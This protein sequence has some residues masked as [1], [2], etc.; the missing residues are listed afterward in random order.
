MGWAGYSVFAKVRALKKFQQAQEIHFLLGDGNNGGDGYVIAWQILSSSK[1]KIFLWQASPPKTKDSLYFFNLCISIKGQIR[2]Y[3]LERFK[4][5][6]NKKIVVFDALFGTGFKGTLDQKTQETFKSINAKKKAFKIAIDI[7]SGVYADGNIFTHLPF[8]ADI[9][10][11]FGGYKIGHLLHPGILFSG[12]VRVLP[13]GFPPKKFLQRRFLQKYK[14]K[15]LRTLDSHKY[16]NGVIHIYGGSKGMEGAAI[17]SAYSFLKLGGG[18]VKIYSDSEDIKKILSKKPEMMFPALGVKEKVEKA[19]LGDLK[20]PV[21]TKMSEKKPKVLVIG[22]GLKEKPSLSFWEELLQIRHLNIILD[23]SVLRS[24]YE[25][26]NIFSGH[27]NGSLTLTPHFS[28]AESL[29]QEEITNVRE[30]TLRISKAYN[31][32][33]YFKGAGGL[34][35][36]PPKYGSRSRPNEIFVFSKDSQ[37]AVGGTG[38]IL[39][40]VIANMMYRY[41]EPLKAIETALLLYLKISRKTAGYLD[42][43]DKAYLTSSQL[44]SGF[45]SMK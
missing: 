39:T 25:Y 32:F 4:L 19:L 31:A 17:L 21:G 26:K 34:I 42:K 29:L 11:T 28:E 8:K 10:Y 7:P 33:V 36:I 23:G 43:N 22:I 16:K 45:Y 38:D 15:R 20:E 5:S 41:N 18:L 40:G 27:N 44:I 37:L 2:V 12:N 30:A 35:G 13:I 9:T 24:I 1:K 14:K 6:G 3:P